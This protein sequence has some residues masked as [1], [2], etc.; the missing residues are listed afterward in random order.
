LAGSDQVIIQSSV[1]EHLCNKDDEAIWML[2]ALCN[3]LGSRQS[4]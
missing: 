2:D 3:A 4:Q 1:V